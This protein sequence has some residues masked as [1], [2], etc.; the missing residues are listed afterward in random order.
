MKKYIYV[1]QRVHGGILMPLDFLLQNCKIGVSTRPDLRVEQVDD[2][3]S[4]RIV[5]RRVYPMLWGAYVKE[6]LLHLIFAPVRYTAKPASGYKHASGGTE[7][8]HLT[9]FGRVLLEVLLF[10]LA[11]DW[12]IAVIAILLTINRHWQWV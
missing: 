7:W 1:M 9:I 6:R 4:G 12:A 3:T 2:S 10:V 5:L 8:F 11:Y